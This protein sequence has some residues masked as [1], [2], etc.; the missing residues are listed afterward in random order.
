LLKTLTISGFK[1]YKDK[2]WRADTQKMVNHKTGKST[3]IEIRNLKFDTGL[4]SNDF[5][6]NR[7]KR[8]R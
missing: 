4:K 3:D 2:Y 5:N 8:G 1:L 6:E 7:L